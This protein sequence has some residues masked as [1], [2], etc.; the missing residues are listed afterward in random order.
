MHTNPVDFPPG[1]VVLT[2]VAPPTTRARN[3]A[4]RAARAEAEF[5]L[6]VRLARAR[7]D[8]AEA[9][10]AAKA[11]SKASLQAAF[12]AD[13]DALTAGGMSVSDAMRSIGKA[14]RHS[15]YLAAISTPLGS[16]AR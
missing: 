5:A 13:L 10:Q 14:G 6:E 3:S 1:T 15:A 12:E 11:T 16:V 8:A 7:R 2:G 9:L 4:T